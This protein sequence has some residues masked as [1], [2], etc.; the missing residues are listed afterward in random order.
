M[1]ERT[2]ANKLTTMINSGSMTVSDLKEMLDEMPDNAVVLFACDYG[3]YC[4]T[5]QAL[6]V[7]RAD[8]LALSDLRLDETSYSRSGLAVSEIEDDD[9]QDPQ[10]LG[11]PV[12]VLG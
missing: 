12:V 5:M 3:D 11:R 4:H 6:P 9:P 8:L 2:I 10:D 7:N 1:S